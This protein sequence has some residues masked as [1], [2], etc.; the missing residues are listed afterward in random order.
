MILSFAMMLRYSFN[1]SADADLL[2][3]AVQNVLSAGV[4]T[5]DIA[6]PGQAPVGTTAMADAAVKELERLATA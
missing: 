2:E 5:V 6:E 3:R 1:L 4:R